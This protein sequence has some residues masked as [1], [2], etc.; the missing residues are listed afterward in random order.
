MSSS[1]SSWI[2]VAQGF[3]LVAQAASKIA[4]EETGTVAAKASRHSIDLAKNARNATAHVANTTIQF[5]NES[6]GS[7]GGG[8]NGG[9]NGSQH[10]RVE[11]EKF[12]MNET[13]IDSSTS[14]S[15]TVTMNETV[16]QTVQQQT[17]DSIDSIDNAKVETGIDSNSEITTATDI[18]SS[19]SGTEST[20]NEEHEKI[21][22]HKPLHAETKVEDKEEIQSIE[23]NPKIQDYSN[24]HNDQLQQ[25]KKLK[26]GQA[27]PSTR[28]GRAMGFA[29]LGKY[30]LS[31]YKKYSAYQILS[32]FFS[33]L[34]LSLQGLD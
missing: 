26:E 13:F 18:S 24:I 2:K 10:D 4:I 31:L 23:N 25:Q 3:K 16:E 8:V 29:S 34:S 14:F 11:F 21:E 28:I 17:N 30:L 5:R 19:S 12:R 22:T 1:T 6:M 15:S 9:I 20:T 33:F 27:V 32:S 7:S